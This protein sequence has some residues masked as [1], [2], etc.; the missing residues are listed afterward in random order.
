MSLEVRPYGE[1]KTTNGTIILSTTN[2]VHSKLLFEIARSL[3]D[4]LEADFQKWEAQ[5]EVKA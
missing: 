5:K 1:V 2:N 4:A 3:L